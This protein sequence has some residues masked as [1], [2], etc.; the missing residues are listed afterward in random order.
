MSKMQLSCKLFIE[1]G[2]A[3]RTAKTADERQKSVFRTNY[4]RLSR[5]FQQNRRHNGCDLLQLQVKYLE[6]AGY[7]SAF[8][9]QILAYRRIDVGRNSTYLGHLL[10]L[11]FWRLSQKNWF[12][13]DL[14]EE[15]LT[16]IRL[17]TTKGTR[18]KYQLISIPRSKQWK[19]KTSG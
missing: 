1:E 3:L 19:Q 10:I 13:A 4:P 9:K 18:L 5:G 8:I 12:E 14:G 2:R 6:T 16:T 15:K 17:N 11:Q 7:H